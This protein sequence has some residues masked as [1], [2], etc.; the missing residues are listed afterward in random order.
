MYVC[1]QITDS[2]VYPNTYPR[3]ALLEFSYIYFK[4]RS[5]VRLVLKGA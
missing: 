2:D 4:V 5:F 1:Q 3:G